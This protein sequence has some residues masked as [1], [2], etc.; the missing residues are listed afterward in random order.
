MFQYTGPADPPEGV[1]VTAVEPASVRVS[2]QSVENADSYTVTFTQATGDD[3]EGL[4][5][6]SHTASVPVT[7]TSATIAVGLDVG[8]DVRDMLRA[9]TTYS[10]TVVAVSDILGTSDDSS[11]TE[12]TTV[13]T[14][15]LISDISH[16]LCLS[17]LLHYRILYCILTTSQVLQKLPAMSEQQSRAPLTSLSSGVTSLPVDW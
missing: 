14:S 17:S 1:M 15:K 10:I 9:Y 2:W 13:Q 7:T 3:Q 12:H 16:A 4:C 6:D 8:S 11:E 5:S